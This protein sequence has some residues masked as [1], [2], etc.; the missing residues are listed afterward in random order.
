VK[1]LNAKLPVFALRSLNDY[2]SWTNADT[3][4]FGVAF[5]ALAIIALALASTGLY[6]V[7]SQSVNQRNHEM[8]IRS[9][10]GAS[11]SCLWR[12][13]FYQG[14]RQYTIGLVIGLAL[15][16]AVGGVLNSLLVGVSSG[17]PITHL[18]VVSMLTIVAAF[19]CGLPA[20]RAAQADPAALL[21]FE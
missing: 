16:F 18:L 21:R 2:V 10:M 20:R 7:I 13:M 11:G 4:I 19:A 9:A 5:T 8:A 14:M 15:S 3:R 6:A 1:D 17:D 12:L